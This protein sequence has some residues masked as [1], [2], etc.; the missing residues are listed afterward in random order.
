MLIY[1]KTC[2]LLLLSVSG[3]IFAMHKNGLSKDNSFKENPAMQPD[4][5]EECVKMYQQYI[6]TVSEGL[7]KKN[8]KNEEKNKLTSKL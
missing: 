2:L 6:A 5:K 4:I 3:V 8:I 1:K 7:K